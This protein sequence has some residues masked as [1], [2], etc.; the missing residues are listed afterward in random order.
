MLKRQ[1]R[2]NTRD[3]PTSMKKDSFK[4]TRVDAPFQ[5]TAHDCGTA[6]NP[7]AVE[8]QIEGGV[9]MTFGQAFTEEFMMDKVWPMTSSFL[10]YKIPTSMDMPE[11]KSMVAEAPDVNGPYGAN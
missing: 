4:I 7:Q 3:K 5:K 11:I 6:I 1:R 8:G 9:S 10:D 2:K